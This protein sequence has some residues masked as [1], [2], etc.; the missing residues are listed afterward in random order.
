MSST[1]SVTHPI[2]ILQQPK[3]EMTTNPYITGPVS[4]TD[5]LQQSKKEDQI[6]K[7]QIQKDQIQKEKS[8]KYTQDT[9]AIGFGDFNQNMSVSIMGLMDDI[10]EKPTH[11]AW[12]EYIIK[13]IKKDDRYNYIVITLMFITMFIILFS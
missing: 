2:P 10:Y 4:S 1:A 12:N 6:Q 9:G 7:D 3:A 13:I 5:S 11:I 8:Q